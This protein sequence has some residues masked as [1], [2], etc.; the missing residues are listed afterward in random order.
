MAELLASFGLSRGELTNQAGTSASRL[1]THLSG[2]VSPSAPLV[3]RTR[4]LAGFQLDHLRE[5]A[6]VGG[7][8]VQGAGCPLDVSPQVVGMGM[9]LVGEGH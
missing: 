5:P 9:N 6:H 1:C 3:V 4:C 2:K 7:E 8:M